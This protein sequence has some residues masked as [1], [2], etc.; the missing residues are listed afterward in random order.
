MFEAV[1]PG[2]NVFLAILKGLRFTEGR[3]AELARRHVELYGL[4]SEAI[5]SVTVTT[6]STVPQLV[7]WRP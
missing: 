2:K 7:S 3:K 1:V 5:G 4:F 6:S